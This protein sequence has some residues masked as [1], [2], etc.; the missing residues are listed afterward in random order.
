MGTRSIIHIY[1][2]NY[3][4][5]VLVSI[6]RQYDGQPD[7]IGMDIYNSLAHRK[8]V[9][10]ISDDRMSCVNGI[11][12]A[13]AV[14]IHDLKNGAGAGAGAGAEAG[15]VYINKPDDSEMEEFTYK[16]WVE[17]NRPSNFLTETRLIHMSVRDGS[18]VIYSG[19]LNEY[20]AWLEKRDE[21]EAAKDD[22]AIDLDAVYDDGYEIGESFH[23]SLNNM[24]DQNNPAERG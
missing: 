24:I 16:L 19:P 3:S 21:E 17:G 4:G 12:C 5:D 2:D 7:G 18:T 1:Q 10:G 13:A 22:A 11:D 15:N 8:L 20:A 14:L 9:N 23:E 6:Y